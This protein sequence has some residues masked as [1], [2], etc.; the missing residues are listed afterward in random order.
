MVYTT[1]QHSEKT[2]I[3]KCENVDKSFPAVKHATTIMNCQYSYRVS[4][5]IYLRLTSEY[6]TW[7]KAL[8]RFDGTEALVLLIA[9]DLRVSSK[10]D[11][12]GRE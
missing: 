9:V 10:E 1:P 5:L 12:L 3:L 2:H 7:K 4:A 6:S 11:L 8:C